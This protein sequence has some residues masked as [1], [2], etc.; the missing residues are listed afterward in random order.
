MKNREYF[1]LAR[2]T[3]KQRKKSS[4]A[5]VRGL[6]IGFII[7]IPLIVVLFGCNVSIN[8]QLNQ[9]PYFL[10]GHMT[11]SDYR[12]PMQG[13]SAEMRA[14]KTISG[15]ENISF[16]T[17]NEDISDLIVYERHILKD[18]ITDHSEI[19]FSIE[20][21]Q[22]I[23][24]GAEESYFS[25]IDNKKSSCFFP[26]N[27]V[28]NYQEGIFVGNCDQGF[29]NKGKKQV[30]VAEKILK[31]NG[32]TAEDVY[33]KNISISAENY[34][35][36]ASFK[37]NISISEDSFSYGK[38]DEEREY[39]S[40][41]IC[42]NYKVV[43]VVKEEVSTL[44]TFSNTYTQNPFMYSDMFFT[45]ENVY[46]ND[47]ESLK[48]YY[49]ANEQTGKRE[50]KYNNLDQKD[51]FNEEFMMLSALDS[52]IG[53]NIS[54]V[55]NTNIYFESASY[56]ALEKAITKAEKHIE[57]VL[58]KK[59]IFSPVNES[60]LFLKLYNTY[61][62][63]RAASYVLGIVGIIIVLCAI[64]NLYSAIKNSVETRKLYLTLMRAIGAR[65]KV[66]PKLY[67][68]ESI[69]TISK[70]NLFIATIGFAI[71]AVLKIVLDTIL[72][73]KNVTYALSIPWIVIVVCIIAVVA[74]LYAI[75]LLFSYLCS[76]RLSKKPIV[77][78]LKNY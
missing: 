36:T 25:I 26:K 58:R 55:F 72:E 61:K 46:F 57:T 34:F 37:E 76:Y 24:S 65:D 12:I 9:T 51:T 1:R 39:L 47:G 67:F 29:T 73:V 20:N 56:S 22:K 11:M 43:G 52:K 17:E 3:L 64:I 49:E 62:Q 31:K 16:F 21:R 38:Q 71:S 60:A 10:Y 41:Y 4:S 44:Y 48:P 50:I 63:I 5:T 6:A 54:T 35:Y 33:M 77:A 13:T 70:A 14:S 40:G 27:L 68:A 2:L 32:L 69:I 15:S 78:V 75:G 42:Q 7:L 74:G 53:S 45:D 59:I 23:L 8:K 18:G 30:I 66:V 28:D 19:T